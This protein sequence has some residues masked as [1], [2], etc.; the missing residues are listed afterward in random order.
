MVAQ[1]AGEQNPMVVAVD[2]V[3]LPKLVMVA[4]QVTEIKVVLTL[5][6]GQ[7]VAVAALELPVLADQVAPPQQVMADRAAHMTYLALGVGTLAAA[8]AEATAVN[9]QV[10]AMPVV[11]AVLAQLLDTIDRKSVV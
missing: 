4:Q 7:V 8:A 2:Q 9:E 6:V 10:M 3:C 1:V 5:K 11:D